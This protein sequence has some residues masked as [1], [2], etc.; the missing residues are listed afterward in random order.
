MKSSA[1][2]VNA[3]SS[4]AVRPNQK[5]L[6]T[7]FANRFLWAGYIASLILNDVFMTL[8]AFY[9]AYFMRFELSLEFF[10]LEVQPAM[11]FYSAL[12]F[13]IMPAWIVVFIITGLDKR[14]N[15]LG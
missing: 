15:L 10:K 3:V 7:I 2:G 1:P 8:L 11:P 4:E 5:P 12:S 9:L 6:S 14:E 13:L